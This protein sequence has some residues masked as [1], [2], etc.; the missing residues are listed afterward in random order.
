[1]RPLGYKTKSNIMTN[2]TNK[3][4]ESTRIA[5]SKEALARNNNLVLLY[6]HEKGIAPKRN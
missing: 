5:V 1:M 6:L 4:Q 3:Y 2:K